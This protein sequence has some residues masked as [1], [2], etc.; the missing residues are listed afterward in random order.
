MT[1]PIS[2]VY[3]VWVVVKSTQTRGA[4]SDWLTNFLAKIDA[5]HHYDK[6]W[7]SYNCSCRK[8]THL[9]SILNIIVI[10]HKNYILMYFIIS[11]MLITRAAFTGT[12]TMRSRRRA[13]SGCTIHL[14]RHTNR[15]AHP[16]NPFIHYLNLY[17]ASSRELLINAPNPNT[18]E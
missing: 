6:Y 18:T 7:I 14:E 5:V 12:S 8:L 13:S 1:L 17:N 4:T 9:N 2:S 15:S 3:S 16:C 10:V 11:F